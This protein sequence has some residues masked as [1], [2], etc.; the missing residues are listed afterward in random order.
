LIT[1]VEA[2]VADRVLGDHAILLP[3]VAERMAADPHPPPVRALDDHRILDRPLIIPR[4][5]QVA[6]TEWQ[7][8]RHLSIQRVNP[9]V[10]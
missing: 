6:L 9:P 7:L 8:F 2:V 10:L 5:D 4:E 3:G 1:P